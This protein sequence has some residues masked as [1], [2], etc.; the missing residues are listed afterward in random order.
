MIKL[1]YKI[2]NK[3]IEEIEV[4]NDLYIL[5]QEVYEN[6]FIQKGLRPASYP[7]CIKYINALYEKGD[8]IFEFYINPHKLVWVMCDRRKYAYELKNEDIIHV[9]LRDFKMF[10]LGINI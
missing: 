6:F 10:D 9:S 4:V 1:L 8:R 7:I 3:I 2:D 5:T